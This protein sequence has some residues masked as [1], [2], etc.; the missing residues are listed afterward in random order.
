MP[1]PKNT[2]LILA[3]M[4]LMFLGAPSFAEDQPEAVYGDGAQQFS[5]ATGSPGE[6]GLLK[7][8]AEAFGQPDNARMAWYKAGSGEALK[9]LKDKKWT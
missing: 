2:L 7:V 8:L 4:A 9:L 6:L 1:R 5:L 3:I